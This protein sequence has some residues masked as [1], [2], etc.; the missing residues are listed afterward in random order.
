[1][2]KRP[3][4]QPL[5]IP[6]PSNV[7]VYQSDNSPLSEN[8]DTAREE[9]L[10]QCLLS[11][12]DESSVSEIIS[13]QK[14]CLEKLEKT[15]A[16]LENCQQISETRLAAAFKDIAVGK[17]KILEIKSDLE[18][19]T[20]KLAVIKRILREKYP[21]QLKISEEILKRPDEEG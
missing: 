15:N 18:Y 11:Q 13:F 6:P 2:S 1:M 16:M 19:I 14:M 21:E 3:N 10:I 5:N 4:I 12:V 9:S 8:E 17:A 7:E 20:K